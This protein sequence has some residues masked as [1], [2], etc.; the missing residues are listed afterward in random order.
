MADKPNL[1][2]VQIFGQTYAVKAGADPGYVE[3]LAAFVD[4]QMTEVSR[5][6]RRRGLGEGGRAG[7]P[8][9]RR[10]GLPPAREEAE[11]AGDGYARA[12]GVARQG[13]GR[14]PRRL[15]GPRCS[16]GGLVRARATAIMRPGSPALFVMAS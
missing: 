10:R 4:S 2:H 16:C 14:R 9:H 3:K 5:G 15:A 8:Q 13:A 11:H 6:D 12:R 7:R 1:V